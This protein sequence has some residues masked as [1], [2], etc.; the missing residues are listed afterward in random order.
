M[1]KEK[2]KWL[3]FFL[4]FHSTDLEKLNRKEIEKL[5]IDLDFLIHNDTVSTPGTTKK[6]LVIF[7]NIKEG[8]EENNTNRS[9]KIYISKQIRRLQ[10]GLRTDIGLLIEFIETAGSNAALFDLDRKFYTQL[11][12][13][14][15]NEG[16]IFSTEGTGHNMTEILL[17]KFLKCLDIPVSFFHKCPEC[18][19]WF[20][21]ASKR[22]KTYCTNKCA[23]RFLMRK[24]RKEEKK[25]SSK[26]YK[27]KL[28][29][30]AKRARKSY[31]KKVQNGNPKV[32]VASRPTKHKK[33]GN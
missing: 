11:R 1:N 28:E 30:G 16:Q 23:T 31:V 8:Y 3:N 19:A 22:E 10:D 25:S 4:K 6:N 26:K 29:E 7:E 33:G 15:N 2:I 9:L 24:Q 32:K 27:K 5:A 18:A 17:F 21:N 14:T 20:V 13:S 12:I